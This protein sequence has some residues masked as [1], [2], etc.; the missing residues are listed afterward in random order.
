MRL[1][2]FILLLVSQFKLGAQ[3]KEFEGEI[4]Y[5]HLYRF[6]L[7]GMD[8]AAILKDFGIASKYY[9]KEGT[10]RWTFDSCNMAEEYYSPKTGDSY[11]RKTNSKD[12]TLNKGG[13]NKLLRYEVKENADTICGYACDRIMIMTC[14]KS[15][16]DNILVR[17]IFYAPE[18]VID[19]ER[20]KK[21]GSY[22]NYEVYKITKSAF[23]RIEM[24]SPYWPFAFRMEATKVVPRSLAMTE[25]T[26]PEDA[27][28]KKDK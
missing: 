9:Y 15:D 6:A 13:Q 23:L 14:D 21:F 1:I 11:K 4:H 27:V 26:M 3:V 16:K 22:C 25:T 18:L 5:Q 28:I 12:Y 20:F 2:I 8:T 19:P 7:K 10:Y 17:N 24:V